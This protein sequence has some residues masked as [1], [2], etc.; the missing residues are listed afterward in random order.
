MRL[1]YRDHG[2]CH[3]DGS[4]GVNAYDLCYFVCD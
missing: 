2:V 1:K 3:A 4:E